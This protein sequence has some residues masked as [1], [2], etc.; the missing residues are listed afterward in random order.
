LDSAQNR[1]TREAL[2]DA[3]A[4]GANMKDD[5]VLDHADS[6]PAIDN[7]TPME[8]MRGEL[9]GHAMGG[10]I[11]RYDSGGSVGAPPPIDPV[12]IAAFLGQGALQAGVAAAYMRNALNDPKNKKA[13]GGLVGYAPGGLVIPTDPEQQKSMLRDAFQTRSNQGLDGGGGSFDSAP[14]LSTSDSIKQNVG[15]FAKGFAGGAQQLVEGLAPLV[16][17]GDLVNSLERKEF[18]LRGID[19][20]P[21]NFSA[22][23]VADSWKGMAAGLAPLVGAG[24]VVNSALGIEN[25]APAAGVGD[26][27]RE[28]AKA[29]SRYDQWTGGQKAEAAGGNVFDIATAILPGGAL[30]RGAR[31]GQAGVKAA[32]LGATASGSTAALSRVAR[33]ASQAA[34]A[35]V[36]GAGLAGKGISGGVMAAKQ[37]AWIRK[38]TRGIDFT[39]LVAPRAA[40]KE[41]IKSIAELQAA[42]PTNLLRVYTDPGL[43]NTTTMA[44]TGLEMMASSGDVG[45]AIGINASVFNNPNTLTKIFSKYQSAR[46]PDRGFH[47]STGTKGGIFSVIAHEYAHVLDQLNLGARSKVPMQLVDDYPGSRSGPTKDPRNVTYPR[48]LRIYRDLETNNFGDNEPRLTPNESFDLYANQQKVTL[49]ADRKTFTGKKALSDF[50]FHEL[51][52]E[53]FREEFDTVTRNRA[54]KLGTPDR[55]N[56]YE[57]AKF[58][59]SNLSGYSYIKGADLEVITGLQAGALDTIRQ[60]LKDSSIYGMSST[61]VQDLITAA[62]LGGPD[63]N[64]SQALSNLFSEQLVN[65]PLRSREPD[66][67]YGAPAQWALRTID[68]SES[69]AEAFADVMTNGARASRGSKTVYNVLQE[70]LSQRG[71]RIPK[72]DKADYSDVT[73]RTQGFLGQG[74]F[75]SE[76][77][78]T[79]QEIFRQYTTKPLYSESE[80]K[81]NAEAA[82][83]R[84]GL[85]SEEDALERMRQIRRTAQGVLARFKGGKQKSE[86]PSGPMAISKPPVQGRGLAKGWESAVKQADEMFDFAVEEHRFQWNPYIP[87][88]APWGPDEDG[89]PRR[90]RIPMGSPF[91]WDQLTSLIGYSGSSSVNKSLRGMDQLP[92]Y[93]SVLKELLAIRP[94][95]SGYGGRAQVYSPGQLLAYMEDNRGM[96]AA[97]MIEAL[98]R[99]FPGN[100]TQQYWEL[101]LTQNLAKARA[102]SARMLD[103]LG[104]IQY[105][106]SAFEASQPLAQDMWVTRFVDDLNPNFPDLSNP[107]S[108]VGETIPNVGYSSTSV[109]ITAKPGTGP[110]QW[111]H[112]SKNNQESNP[113]QL[114]RVMKQMLIRAGVPAIWFGGYEGELLFPR[115][116]D[117]NVLGQQDIR[118]AAGYGPEEMR[119]A[120]EVA[121]KMEEMTGQAQP[122][123]FKLWGTASLNPDNRSTPTPAD[124]G[125]GE[126]EPILKA[127]SGG[128]W[129]NLLAPQSPTNFRPEYSD[130]RDMPLYHAL[131]FDSPGYMTN[132]T[133]TL[134]LGNIPKKK[135]SEMPMDFGSMDFPD[136]G[137][138]GSLAAGAGRAF[139]SMAMGDLYGPSPMDLSQW[140]MSQ[141][142]A[143]SDQWKNVIVPK[144]EEWGAWRMDYHGWPYP[145]FDRLSEQEQ[146]LIAT[147]QKLGDDG[148]WY[149]AEPGSGARSIYDVTQLLGTIGYPSWWLNHLTY[150]YGSEFAEWFTPKLFGFMPGTDLSM[151]AN[152]GYVSGPGG[153]KSDMIP[154]M[155]SN[156]EFVM[157]AAATRHWGADRLHAMNKYE[158]GGLVP[159]PMTP[160]IQPPM[161]IEPPPPPPPSGS[162]DP[163]AFKSPTALDLLNKP[164]ISRTGSSDPDA[165]KNLDS[166][167]PADLVGTVL[168]PKGGGSGGSASARAPRS[169][170]PRAILGSAPMSENHMNPAL[171]AGIKGGF[172]TVGALVSQAAAIG[173]TAASAGANGGVPIPGAGQAASA[174]TSAGFQMAGDVAVGAANIISSLLVGT[175]TPSDTGQGYG[176]PL[177]PQQQPGAG[178]NNFQSIHNGNVV[179]NNLS[180]YSR[181]KDRKDAQR[182][183]PFFSRVNQ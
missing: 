98:R 134:S 38:N 11:R 178:M 32:E 68:R 121:R 64:V 93:T 150:R 140:D 152:G 55:Y 127:M 44:H 6:T 95:M 94:N 154:A 67:L 1:R 28:L 181:L 82:R 56:S 97:A 77:S 91:D 19:P 141:F 9:G 88:R 96:P 168:S 147:P 169:K 99:A 85:R 30:F 125:Y 86:L 47:P 54:E 117:F 42:A 183:A 35:I 10:L 41:I 148:V 109:G 25:A 153:P 62:M 179:T 151:M 48:S 40:R 130:F 84:L 182:A 177:L 73:A 89:N 143:L 171:A 157:N 111:R 126:L 161:K 60:T 124:F 66:G 69:M 104:T 120:A 106:D 2:R 105:L 72:I 176:A 158:A 122:N 39:D 174:I 15:N 110:L 12:W 118:A 18:Q 131:S 87:T 103:N 149:P 53:R 27:W 80:A 45:G 13:N 101:L 23:G 155:L 108:L 26:S 36:P 175:V 34:G 112:R 144:I 14:K 129:T 165:F 138:D 102:A 76:G 58:I 107:E 156:G 4:N 115:G 170:D 83:A 119:Y 81:T 79:I 113:F 3:I 75:D 164:L 49:G 100:S 46:N 137:V 16:G 123:K 37:A 114:R 180:E 21:N 159:P 172:N 74:M 132:I 63:S 29:T 142:P 33:A 160:I 135:A 22:P 133:D 162:S 70:Q 57:F 51:L 7:R 8:I 78:Q 52:G 173:A 146:S 24:N 166:I 61:Q 163:D 139:D 65:G 59:R 145:R 136:P 31:A 128:A 17:A 92:L 43:S 5:G 167:T 50:R 116:L 20:G 90:N 71:V